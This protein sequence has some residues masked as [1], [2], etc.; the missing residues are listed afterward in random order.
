[1]E[2]ALAAQAS[3]YRGL[4]PLLAL[5]VLGACVPASLGAE[6]SFLLIASVVGFIFSAYHYVLLI[7]NPGTIIHSEGSEWGWQCDGCHQ[8]WPWEVSTLVPLSGRAEAATSGQK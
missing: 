1:M 7:V 5:S 6:L 2:P 8:T 4:S 3:E